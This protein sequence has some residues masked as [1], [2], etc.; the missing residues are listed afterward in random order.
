[1]VVVSMPIMLS[2]PPFFSLGTS[3]LSA[4]TRSLLRN[5]LHL[6][7]REGEYR[8]HSCL[9]LWLRIRSQTAI[10]KLRFISSDAGVHST[11]SVLP[12]PDAADPDPFDIRVDPEQ[13]EMRE[14]ETRN[15]QLLAGAKLAMAERIRVA[16]VIYSD[17]QCPTALASGECSRKSCAVLGWA[18]DSIP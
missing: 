5:Q 12:G 9:A 10:T 8:L 7:G 6:G 3:E 14:S 4:V 11:V 13:A 17:F 18:S 2:M 16:V 15:R 1:M